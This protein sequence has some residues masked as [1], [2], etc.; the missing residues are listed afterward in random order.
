MAWILSIVVG[1]IRWRLRIMDTIARTLLKR[2]AYAYILRFP[3][4]TAGAMLGLVVGARGA[5]RSLLGNLFDIYWPSG[6]FLLS[7]T[8]FSASWTVMTTWRLI[9]LRGPER[10]HLNTFCTPY[11]ASEEGKLWHVALSGL[12]GLT[13]VVYAILYTNGR[14]R[15]SVSLPLMIIMAAL[16][17]LA[18]L[19]LLWVATL[20]QNRFS[21]LS[22]DCAPGQRVAGVAAA[23]DGEAGA[24]L[25]DGD[26][27]SA[28]TAAMAASTGTYVTASPLM[29]LPKWMFPVERINRMSARATPLT[30][31]DLTKDLPLDILKEKLWRGYFLYNDKDG[32]PICIMHGHIL[33]AVFFLLTLALYV[34]IG[35]V[36][37]NRLGLEPY[38]PTLGYV[39]LLLT[40]LCWGL[41]GVAFF[42][43]RFRIP[44]ALPLLVLFIVTALPPWSDHYY[45][46]VERT[47]ERRRIPCVPGARTALDVAAASASPTAGEPIILVAANGGGIQAGAWATVVLTE[48]Q[49]TFGDSFGK[50]IR[51]VSSVSGGS[52][53][54][55]YFVNE[56]DEEGRP[57]SGDELDKIVERVE[58]SS[59]DEVAWGLGYPDV[60]RS[61]TSYG[62]SWDRGRALEFAWL[63]QDLGEQWKNR[64][65]VEAGLSKWHEAVIA[66]RRPGSIFNTTVSDTGQRLPLSTIDLPPCSDGKQ[67]QDKLFDGLGGNDISV[68]TA[69]RLSASFPY[70]SPAARADYGGALQEQP[71]IVDGG[72]YDN[73]GI[74][75]LIEWL[76]YELSRPDHNISR[77]LMVEIRGSSTNGGYEFNSGRG[78][79]Y[80]SFAPLGTLLHVRDTGQFAHNRVE[81]QLLIDKW[82]GGSGS[83]PVT[84]TDVVFEYDGA[85]PPLSWH[86]NR[87]EKQDLKNSWT[88]VADNPKAQRSMTETDKGGLSIVRDFLGQSH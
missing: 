49:K 9:L 38:L 3:L 56:Y 63:R 43:D 17:F 21:S 50:R 51:V 28:A 54:A 61:L 72:Y 60:L 15:G 35:I 4:L 69:A 23:A 24:T 85:S 22:S 46:V 65:G 62:S 83:R 57:P 76:D 29:L 88:H 59:L 74:S 71:H 73:Y 20:V 82:K 55:M 13:V 25:I 66:G 45:P 64:K 12:L 70:V 87:L 32:L 78:W 27:S 7:L 42:L 18:S 14:N 47:Q 16:G 2:L 6:I 1:L 41:T 33:A 31:R 81:L 19:G 80:Q 84:I 53:G 5:A 86:L 8:A 39:M 30:F 52:T 11:K 34:V 58:G 67:T 75:S 79:L 48:L 44:V 77:V 10:F 40:L 26:A 36:K 68:V 37:F